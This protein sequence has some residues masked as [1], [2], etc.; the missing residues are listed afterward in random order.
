MY[1]HAKPFA[2]VA[3]TLFLSASHW[4]ATLSL[5][6]RP[7]QALEPPVR[8][9]VMFFGVPRSSS[10]NV[11]A[12]LFASVTVRVRVFSYPEIVYHRYCHVIEDEV[13][14]YRPRYRSVTRLDASYTIRV[15]L[16]TRS[17]TFA[18]RLFAS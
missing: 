18:I 2:S 17:T 6:A 11:D 5:P 7:Q 4:L 3:T 14:F 16:F 9:P 10:V 12:T 1:R 8:G 13:W 15:I